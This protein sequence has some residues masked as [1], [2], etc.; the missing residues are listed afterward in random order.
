MSRIVREDIAT[1]ARRLQ[2]DAKVLGG[3]TILISGSAGFLGKYMV[4]ALCR[5]NDTVLKKKP[6]RIIA[7]DNFITGKKHPDFDYSGRTDVLEVWADVSYPLPLREDV[8]YIMHAAG[9]AS[10][11]FYKKFPMETIESAISGVKNLLE[12]A[13]KSKDFKSFLFFSSSEVYG[14]PISSAIPT[15]ETY[16]GYVSST[17][18]RACYDESKRMGESIA[19]IYHD[20]LRIPTKIVRPFNVFGPGMN[21]DDRRVSPMFA[22]T[23]LHGK[24]IPV[25]GDG[26]QTRTFTYVTDATVGFLQVLLKGKA[27]EVYNIGSDEN[28]ISMKDL[29]ALF[30]SVAGGDASY[31]LIPYPEHYPAGEPQRRCPDITKARTELGFDPKVGL[32]EG[33]RRFLEWCKYDSNYMGRDKKG[34]KSK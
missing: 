7:V 29:A 20:H 4:G 32:R 23:V 9:I 22:L 8:H 14:E 6:C 13:R 25:H 12:L 18:P 11:V 10:P 27:G 5:L 15:P 21:H 28:E 26:L 24:Q 31:K 34:N 3:K 16:H 2:T 1:I 30:V 33:T 17:G 19:T